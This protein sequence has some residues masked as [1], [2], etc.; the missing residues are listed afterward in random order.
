MSDAATVLTNK[1][2][3]LATEYAY[4]CDWARTRGREELRK[5]DEAKEKL[6]EFVKLNLKEM[7]SMALKISLT[8]SER[9]RS[10]LYV[11]M[12]IKV[13]EN[14]TAVDNNEV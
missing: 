12:L 9:K 14:I 11:D 1:I 10:T 8:E 6:E 3:Q 5:A 7:I 2:M 13:Q 4:Q